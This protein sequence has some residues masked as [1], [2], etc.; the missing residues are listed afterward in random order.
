M[1]DAEKWREVGR[2]AAA[3][4]LEDGRHDVQAALFDITVDT[5]YS[6]G[7]PTPEQVRE[8]RM[9]LNFTRRVLESYIA[10]AAGCQPWGDPV[11]DIPFGRVREV[12]HLPDSEDT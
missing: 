6:G 10:P 2:R 12:Y 7:D 9:A 3:D 1:D 4:E 11:P 8:A 5:M